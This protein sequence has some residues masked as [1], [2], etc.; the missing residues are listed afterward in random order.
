VGLTRGIGQQWSNELEFEKITYNPLLLH[1]KKKWKSD[2]KGNPTST[3]KLPEYP[4]Q[5]ILLAVDIPIAP[6]VY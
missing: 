3:V 5:N 1:G 2:M 4:I 6:S